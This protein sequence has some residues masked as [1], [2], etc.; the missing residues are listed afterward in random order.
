MKSERA[1]R[2]RAGAQT[3][4]P[5]L[6][7]IDGTTRDDPHGAGPR[8]RA[9][10]W[11]CGIAAMTVGVALAAESLRGKPNAIAADAGASPLGAFSRAIPPDAPPQFTDP[12]MEPA[13]AET[14]PVATAHPDAGRPVASDSSRPERLS[15]ADAAAAGTRPC[16]FSLVAKTKARSFGRPRVKPRY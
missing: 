12:R 8:E 1:A 16:T 13:T 11:L 15:V 9:L 14:V 2:P 6:G 5:R 7:S 10:T 3:A 4:D